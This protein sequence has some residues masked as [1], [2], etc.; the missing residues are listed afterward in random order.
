[1]LPEEILDFRRRVPPFT[2]ERAQVFQSGDK[3]ND[4]AGGLRPILDRGQH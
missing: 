2:D 4:A 3:G 1:M